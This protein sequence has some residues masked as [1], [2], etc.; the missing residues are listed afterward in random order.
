MTRLLSIL[1]A[2]FLA[3]APARADPIENLPVD[4]LTETLVDRQDER[5]GLRVED[6]GAAVGTAAG[7]G[8][9]AVGVDRVVDRGRC[10]GGLRLRGLGSHATPRGGLRVLPDPRRGRG[11]C[12]QCS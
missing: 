4:I 11:P 12:G 2:A 1:I 8:A 10:L 9:I 7:T 6:R 3:V 5:M